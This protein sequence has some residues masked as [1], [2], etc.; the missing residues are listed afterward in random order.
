MSDK[1]TQT[2]SF[3]HGG[4]GANGN[5][6]STNSHTLCEVCN[7]PIN[8]QGAQDAAS[9][10]EGDANANGTSSSKIAKKGREQ[11]GKTS[12]GGSANPLKFL[13]QLVAPD[14]QAPTMKTNLGT[15]EV[16]RPKE[17]DTWLWN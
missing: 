10:S 13:S 4:H 16:I 2:E 3:V 15:F 1:Q 8:C 11:Q 5:G 12:D 7:R 14:P 6:N 17:D 9:T